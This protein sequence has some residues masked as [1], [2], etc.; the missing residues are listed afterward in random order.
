M[1]HNRLPPNENDPQDDSL[2]RSATSLPEVSG[3]WQLAPVKPD[4]AMKHAALT[5]SRYQNGPPILTVGH[6][7]DGAAKIWEAM[8]AAAPK[9]ETAAMSTA[10][11]DVLAER[12]RQVESEGWTPEHDDQHSSGEMAVAAMCYAAE[13]TGHLT[14]S[15]LARLWPWPHVWWKPTTPRRDLVKAAALILAEIERLDRSAAP[16]TE[17][18]LES[19]AAGAPN[20]HGQVY[21][22]ARAHGSTHEGALCLAAQAEAEYGSERVKREDLVQ[23]MAHLSDGMDS[24]KSEGVM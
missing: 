12:R 6:E 3:G 8:L 19:A 13:A 1:V 4:I 21:L 5:V 14:D 11:R 17:T 23:I 20:L 9:P 7:Y 22:W 15:G 16:K 18:D 24:Q 10:A 2:H